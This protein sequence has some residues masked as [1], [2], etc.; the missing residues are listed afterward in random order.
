MRQDQSKTAPGCPLA[1]I[2]ERSVACL[3]PGRS[4]RRRAA[5]PRAKADA[6]LLLGLRPSCE[7][8]GA[9]A[10]QHTT[11]VRPGSR[12]HRRQRLWRHGDHR[13][14]RA[15]L[16]RPRRGGRAPADDGAL[17]ASGPTAITGSCRISCMAT[18]ASPSLSPGKMTAATSS[19]RPFFWRACS[20]RDSTSTGKTTTKAGCVPGSTGCGRRRSGAGTPRAAATCSTGTGARTTAGA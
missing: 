20:A 8:P 6:S 3:A 2:Q 19:R 17:S 10:Q 14:R 11:G 5:R 1:P 9:R 15:G 12:D 16:D 13:R 7:R 18:P 4:R